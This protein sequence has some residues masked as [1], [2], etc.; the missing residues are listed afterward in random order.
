VTAPDFVIAGAPKAGTTWLYR[1][2]AANPRIFLTAIKE[3]RFY[4]VEGGEAPVFVGPGDDAWLANLIARRADYEGLFAGAE[5]D[6]LR[7]EASSDYLYR[8]TI[9]APRLAAEAPDARLVFLLRDPVER[10]YSNWLHHRR[11]GREP[12]AFDAALAAEAERIEAGWAWW[13]HYAERGF[14]AR[15]LEPFLDC[16]PADQILV[17]SYAEVAADPAG[18]LRRVSS[19]LGVETVVPAESGR[20]RNQSLVARSPLHRVARRALRPN[21][22]ARA[23]VPR[24]VRGGLR[25]RVDRATLHRPELAA[26]DGAGLRARYAADTERLARAG[27]VDVSSWAAA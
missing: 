23:L 18:L 22:A 15:D 14:Y 1:N 20:S 21:A 24:R 27:L 16:F 17:A 9:A 8:S 26:A 19:F 11:D 12:L 3:P 25:R 2:L 13:W 10:A 4:A 5:P 6:L 7:G